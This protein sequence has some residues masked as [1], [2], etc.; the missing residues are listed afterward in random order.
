MQILQIDLELQI[1][2]LSIIHSAGF[3]KENKGQF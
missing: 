1:Q 3:F 2:C